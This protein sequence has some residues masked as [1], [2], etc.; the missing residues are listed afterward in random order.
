[1]VWRKLEQHRVVDYAG[2]V[3]NQGHIQALANACF[4]YIARR[5]PLHQSGRVRA[6]DF[7]LALA[8]DIPYLHMLT[9]MPIVFLHAGRKGFG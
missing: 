4:A 8:G 5:H 7:H 6:F 9:H 3:I 2:F 1:M